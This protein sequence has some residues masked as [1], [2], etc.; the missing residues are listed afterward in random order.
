MLKENVLNEKQQTKNDRNEKLGRENVIQMLK[1]QRYQIDDML[2]DLGGVRFN[3]DLFDADTV[4]DMIQSSF[5]DIVWQIKEGNIAT[6]YEMAARGT[7]KQ[8][9][10]NS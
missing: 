1:S 5:R 10:K 9:L 4:N 6:A 2:L 8:W 7:E 3:E